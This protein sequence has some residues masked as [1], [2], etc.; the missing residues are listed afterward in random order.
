MVTLTNNSPRSAFP[1]L[2]ALP[3]AGRLRLI[4]VAIFSAL[5]PRAAQTG[6][7]PHIEVQ[8]GNGTPILL[9][10]F[11]A[12]SGGISFVAT[13][14]A[15][16]ASGD[17]FGVTEGGGDANQDGTVFEI[18]AGS[19]VI[20]TLATF[21]SATT[22]SSPGGNLII[23]SAGDLFGTAA[24]GGSNNCGT[25]WEL[26]K[27][28]TAVVAFASFTPVN[29]NGV[30]QNPGANGIAMDGSGDL[31]GTTAGNVAV[32]S[33]GT[34]W[35]LPSG[36]GSIQTLAIFNGSNGATPLGG[37]VIDGSGNVYG[38][39][40][41]GG[42]DIG[43]TADPQG[44]GVVWELPAG[45]G[46]IAVLSNFDSLSSGEFPVGGVVLDSKGDLF[47]TTS[48][49]GNATSSSAGDGTVWEIP[50]QSVTINSIA[51]F[52][53]A[54]GATPRGNLAADTLGNIY[55]TASAG[56]SNGA[57]PSSRWIRAAQAPPL[58]R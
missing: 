32:G 7:A 44:S 41:Y 31:F 11:P 37:L 22:G 20:T 25:V 23:D 57:A 53:G 27:G 21:S 52:T 4:R 49:G 16:D 15:I 42:D 9:A 24:N 50:A 45:T 56:G 1:T 28:A 34:V 19:G 13:G 51:F 38:V 36:T 46:Q 35:E 17:L 39:T 29:V 26:P 14:P 54:N 48:S 2:P 47:G 8:P 58:P 30:N 43:T 18:V 10:S 33:D 3:P 6:P 5:P 55:G 40:Q 12:T